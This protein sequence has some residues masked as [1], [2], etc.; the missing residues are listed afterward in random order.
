L[1]LQKELASQTPLTLVVAVIISVVGDGN[2]IVVVP[3][4]VG[5]WYYSLKGD[6]VNRKEVLKL[7]EISDG[8]TRFIL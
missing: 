2:I 5:D 1:R 7:G 8:C 3:L 6:M 4:G